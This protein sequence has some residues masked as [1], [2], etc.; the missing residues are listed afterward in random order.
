MAN[1]LVNSG[2]NEPIALTYGRS[3]IAVAHPHKGIKI[4]EHKPDTGK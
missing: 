1:R 2:D 4:W 3:R